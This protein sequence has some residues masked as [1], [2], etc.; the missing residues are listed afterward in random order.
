MKALVNQILPSSFVDGPGNRMVIF[1]QGCDLGCLYCHN[2]ETISPCC[3]CGD[4]VPNCP[5]G[6][7]SLDNGTVIWEESLCVDCGRCYKTCPHYATP[8]V[9]EMT[10]QDVMTEVKSAIPFIRGIT[11]SGGECSL[12]RDFLVEMFRQAKALGLSTLMDSNGNQQISKDKELMNCCDGIMLD[13]K[14]FDND[15][16][17]KLT[18]QP[19]INV[20]EN[21]VELAK[22]G[23]L[24]EIRTVIL[25]SSPHN[26]ETVNGAT[27]LLAPYAKDIQYKLIAFRPMG[28]RGQAAGW[29]TPTREEL[30]PLK[31]IAK[32][33]GFKKVIVI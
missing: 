2:P 15:F 20:L 21:A 25:P 23:K 4:C 5:T 33:G 11:T 12:Q 16:H 7:L 13:I 6:A 14:A 26:L 32:T 29:A 27:K 8:R 18:G 30:E 10:V 24:A 19:N 31:E 22:M 1:F 9:K 17:K 28:V 3:H